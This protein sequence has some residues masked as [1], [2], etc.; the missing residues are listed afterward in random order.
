MKK[1]F[2]F[3]L[4]FFPLLLTLPACSEREE[5]P[6]NTGMIT[7]S[8]QLYGSGPYYAL[9][10][11]FALGKMVRTLDHPGPDLTLL[12]RTSPDNAVIESVYLST[13]NLNDSFVFNGSFDGESSARNFFD[14]YLEVDDASGYRG[15]ADSLAPWQVWTFRTAD[16]HYAKLLI[17]SVTKGFRDGQPYG[18]VQLRFVY[19]PDGS[20]TFPQ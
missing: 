7:L 19:Q 11:N 16:R 5:I 12:V 17:L 8:S 18:E 1:H 20:R 13:D 2:L 14:N 3:V 15:I 4:F 6:N 9:G 10:Y